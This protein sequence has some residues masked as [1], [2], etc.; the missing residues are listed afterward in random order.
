MQPKSRAPCTT[1][2]IMISPGHGG[3]RAQNCV[4]GLGHEPA[5]LFRSAKGRG[6]SSDR[7]VAGVHGDDFDGDWRG[8]RL[9]LPA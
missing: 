3:A 1:C 7:R 2:S 5:R 8:H 4:R 9:V 6:A